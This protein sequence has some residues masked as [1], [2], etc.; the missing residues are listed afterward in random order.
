MKH[1]LIYT[2]PEPEKEEHHVVQEGD[3]NFED[4]LKPLREVNNNA[5]YIAAYSATLEPTQQGDLFFIISN[6]SQFYCINFISS[7]IPNCFQVA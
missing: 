1:N 4:K 5:G 3:T 7:M 2:K 6:I